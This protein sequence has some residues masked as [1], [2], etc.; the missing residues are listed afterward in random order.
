MFEL[1]PRESYNFRRARRRV[2]A[3]SRAKNRRCLNL[4]RRINQREVRLRMARRIPANLGKLTAICARLISTVTERISE[5]LGDRSVGSFDEL[6]RVEWSRLE[7]RPRRKRN[8]DRWTGGGRVDKRLVIGELLFGAP[9][10]DIIFESKLRSVRWLAAEVC[11]TRKRRRKIR[12][13][14]HDT[15]RS[16]KTAR[17]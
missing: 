17:Y 12:E 15:N 13:I 6:N 7:R 10:R 1:I 9:E 11:K 4:E 3:L 14:R 16:R 2:I 8:G 5:I